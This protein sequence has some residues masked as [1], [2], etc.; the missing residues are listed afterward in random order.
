[1]FKRSRWQNTRNK[2]SVCETVY[3]SLHISRTFVIFR[4]L[5]EKQSSQWFDF[6]FIAFSVFLFEWFVTRR[7]ESVGVN[8]CM[9]MSHAL[10]FKCVW[11]G[12]W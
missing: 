5:P 7:Y 11:G 2:V 9:E 10:T 1:M 6:P 4:H 12:F 3:T 8:M